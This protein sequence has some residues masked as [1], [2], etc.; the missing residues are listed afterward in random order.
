MPKRVSG[1]LALGSLAAAL[2]GGSAAGQ[3]SPSSWEFQI[4]PYAWLAG[5][6]GD[7]GAAPGLPAQPVSLSFGDVWDDLDYGG[8]VLAS[9]RRDRWAF[10]LDASTVKTTSRESGAGPLVSAISVESKTANLALSVART[11]TASERHRLDA[12]LGARAWRLDNE[13]TVETTAAGPLRSES[14]T[15]WIDPLI[16][17][18]L[19]YDIAARWSWLIT[20]EIGGFGAGADFTWGFLWGA[21]YDVNDW[22]ALSCGWRHLSVDYD[23]D[24]VV[25]DVDQTGPVLG[26]TF[27]F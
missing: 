13:L 22:L 18:A 10:L 3:S 14:D 12:Y 17:A 19:T 21:T 26:A 27:R 24:G 2:A 15:D 4:T 7:L 20:G 1:L 23:D 8:F 9:A 6:D 16:G 5:I 25:Y 11:L